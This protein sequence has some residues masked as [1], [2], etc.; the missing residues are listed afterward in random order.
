MYRWVGVYGEY[1]NTKDTKGC[2]S[3]SDMGRHNEHIIFGLCLGDI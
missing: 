2:S 3:N 1:R